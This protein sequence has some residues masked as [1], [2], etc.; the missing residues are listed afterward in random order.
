MSAAPFRLVDL[1][2]EADEASLRAELREKTLPSHDAAV[3]P[4]GLSGEVV[5]ARRGASEVGHIHPS[6]V[7]RETF[8]QIAFVD[9]LDG[10]VHD[11]PEVGAPLAPPLTHDG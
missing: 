8:V 9:V 7:I 2:D 5:T 1:P 11:E 6:L 4:C 3:G 10:R